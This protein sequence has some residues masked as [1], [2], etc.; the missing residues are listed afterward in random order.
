MADSPKNKKKFDRD[1]AKGSSP[2]G[3]RQVST[4]REE[5]PKS[6][7]SNSEEKS[8]WS[9]PSLPNFLPE[10][11][12]NRKAPASATE[13]RSVFS[14]LGSPKIRKSYSEERN[15]TGG[16]ESP[17]NKSESPKNKKHDDKPRFSL[18]DSPKIK[19]GSFDETKSKN[20]DSPRSPKNKKI[21][22]DETKS[23]GS[24]SQ[25][26]RKASDDRWRFTLLDSPKKAGSFEKDSERTKSLSS[27]SSP[28][29]KKPSAQEDKFGEYNNVTSLFIYFNYFLNYLVSKSADVILFNHC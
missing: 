16:A 15:T 6:K 20:Y 29:S 2:R 9:L 14:L 26:I 19:K 28:K 18:L 21:S 8:K 25:K 10:S 11:P 4:D 27:L 24:E 7:K 5:S 22:L 3:G 17:K 12:K 23:K 13:E 1:E